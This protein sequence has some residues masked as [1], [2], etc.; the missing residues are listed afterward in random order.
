MSKICHSTGSD[1][2]EMKQLGST[3]YIND[4]KFAKLQI[5]FIHDLFLAWQTARSGFNLSEFAK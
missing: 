3:I 2:S 4:K 5:F 1:W